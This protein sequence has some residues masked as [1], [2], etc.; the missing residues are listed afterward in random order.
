MTAPARRRADP[1]ESPEAG[2]GP[3]EA[4]SEQAR[5]ERGSIEAGER[6]GAG[7]RPIEGG[8]VAAVLLAG[9]PNAGKT[10]LF[11]ALS[12]ARARV[13]NYPGVTVDRRAAR[14][15]L[16]DREI[17]LVDV[18]GTYSLSARSPEEQLAADSVLGRLDAT[19]DAII[20]T[21]DATA[22]TRNLYLALQILESGVPTVIAL[23]MMDEA[24]AQGIEID[25][26]GLGAR[27]GARV[28]PVVAAQ[29]EGLETL[30]E[31][32]LKVL[33]EAEAG[34]RHEPVRVEFEPQTEADLREVQQ[35]IPWGEG[36]AIRRAWAI[37]AL[38]SLGDDGIEDIPAELR[39]KVDAIRARAEQAGRSLDLELISTRYRL[40][41]EAVAAEVT[42]PEG[43]R[44]PR[45][46]RLD[47]IL[48]HPISGF[49][50]FAIV[51]MA[52]FEALFT[53][54]GPL[55]DLVDAG[56]GLTQGWIRESME[57]GRL[58]ELLADGVVQGVGNVLVFVPQIALLF[59]FIGFLEDS[60]YL[61]RVA[62]VIDRLMAG[63]GLHGKAF[64]P[65]LSGFACAVPAVMATR[66]IE[67]RRD[68][69]VTM[70]ALPLMSCS[71]RLPVYVLVIAV[72]FGAQTRV[73]G[74]VSAGAVALFAMYFLSVIGALGAAA[75]MRRTVL[76]GKKPTFVLELPPYRLPLARNLIA[77][78]WTRVRTF[79]VDAG[80][81]ILA[82]SV[83]LWALLT[84][85][86]DPQIAAEHGRLRAEA[87]AELS[88]EL[89]EAR[90]GAL[91]R[92]EAAA[93]RKAS[94]AG[95]IGQAMEP[96]LEPL[97]FDWRIGVGILAAFGAR[98]AFVSTMGIVFGV[99][100]SDE[101]SVPLREALA[102][103]ERADG[104]KL[105]PP[106]AGISLMIFFVFACQCMSTIAIVKR[107][108]GSWK[109]PLL[110]F[111]Y[112]S[113]LA[114]LASLLVYQ[115]GRAMGWGLG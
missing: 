115:V 33:E 79:I 78:T 90:L 108:S 93:Q 60:G 18:P 96:L 63:V 67:N 102:N 94:Y 88:S 68:R 48:T 64:V 77:S 14:M 11:N 91:D 41:D 73:W 25:A 99:G 104:S 21:V 109:W 32:L 72:V 62:F 40:L 97:G 92:A 2:S 85:P 80:T 98:E 75:L 45:T 43:D 26:E 9:N 66:T 36:E 57:A 59:L 42:I 10:T 103:A 15:R 112:M 55:V 24:R 52:L 23:T 17:E 82:L 105:L 3:I 16:G 61:A 81:I 31:G 111:V 29:G 28:I 65:L 53:W 110:L 51:M 35:L 58:R 6:E 76:K 27:L 87:S 50:V 1:Q 44:R 71:A 89:R 19:P 12:G 47:S 7:V 83:I 46:R 101:A 95:Q 107:E 106:I 113:T 56:I 20:V 22:L 70:L 114:Y 8:A 34:I 37:W 100:E 30:R 69:L 86:H 74:L 54:S 49:I 13:G 38:L 39:E 84:F 4:G 5:A